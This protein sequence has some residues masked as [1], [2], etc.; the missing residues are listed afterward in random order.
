V[1]GSAAPGF[2][3]IIKALNANT[4]YDFNI[5]GTDYIETLSSKA[6]VKKHYVLPDNK[7]PT[8]AESLLNLCKREHVDVVLP[9]RTDDQIPICQNYGEFKDE[10]IEPAIV[11]TNSDLLDILM[12]KKKLM[13]YCREVIQIDTPNFS[14]AVNSDELRDAAAKLGY[15]EVPVAIKPCYSNGS[16]G[17][18][19]LDEKIDKRKHFFNE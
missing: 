2:V 3:S 16:R 10:G 14:S 6:F 5:I 1:T 12:N 9:I 19:I 17:F 13:E 11:T 7:S 15:P 8:F 4:T 18:R